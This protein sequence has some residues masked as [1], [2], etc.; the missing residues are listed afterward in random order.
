MQNCLTYSIHGV[1]ES[2]LEMRRIMSSP[3]Y[4]LLYSCLQMIRSSE[5]TCVTGATALSHISATYITVTALLLP[6]QWINT[7]QWCCRSLPLHAVGVQHGRGDVGL[8]RKI[9]TTLTVP[10]WLIAMET[11]MGVKVIWRWCVSRWGLRNGQHPHRYTQRADKREFA[12]EARRV[13]YF[14][15]CRREQHLRQTEMLKIK[16]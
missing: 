6:S 7:S 12:T 4:H 13:Y 9:A 11:A 14:L 16:K 1:R 2:V 5:E 3:E 8:F 10:V 15:L